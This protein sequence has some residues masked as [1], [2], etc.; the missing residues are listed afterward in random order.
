MSCIIITSMQNVLKHLYC[1]EAITGTKCI[2]HPSY[3]LRPEEMKV[4]KQNY[5]AWVGRE[6]VLTF[7]RKQ[8]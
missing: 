6:R 1:M 8:H 7:I 5:L 4:S 3:L 2:T